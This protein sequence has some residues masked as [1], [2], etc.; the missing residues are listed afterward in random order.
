MNATSGILIL[1]AVSLST[2]SCGPSNY[3]REKLAFEE[4]KYKDEQ[5]AKADAARREVE[6]KQEQVERWRTCR[7]AA[8]NDFNDEINNWGELIPGKHGL[9]RGPANQLQDMKNRRQ[10]KNEQCDRNFPKGISW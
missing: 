1:A 2:M 6:D 8:E 5:T 7:V 9:R 4:Q 10:Q 3:E